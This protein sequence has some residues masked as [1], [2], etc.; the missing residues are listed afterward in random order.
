MLVPKMFESKVPVMTY[1]GLFAEFV[2]VS[3]GHFWMFL[4]WILSTKL[5]FGILPW[6]QYFRP[7]D[8][9]KKWL[10]DKPN[11]HDVNEDEDVTETEGCG[12][13]ICEFPLWFS[14]NFRLAPLLSVILIFVFKM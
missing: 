3:R 14:F 4:F 9:L 12:K 11:V 5:I 13:C 10:T 7:T 8:L 6:L 1:E 2:R